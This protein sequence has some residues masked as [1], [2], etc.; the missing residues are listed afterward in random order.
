MRNFSRALKL[1]VCGAAAASMLTLTLPEAALAG[2]MRVAPPADVSV[3]TGVTDVRYVQRR[4]ARR[5]R[6]GNGAA[7]AAG[8]GL[9]ALGIGAAIANGNRQDEY[10]PAYGEPSYGYPAYGYSADGYSQYSYGP[11][12]G[13]Y[14]GA[15]YRGVPDQRYRY[16]NGG[17]Y[18]QN[19]ARAE[20]ERHQ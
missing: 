18:W 13:G 2:P 19:K 16:G 5:G 17:N 14:R 8:F 4:V 6:G 1:S 10:Y 20:R 15:Y 11:A 3:Q 9:L 12:G 7:A